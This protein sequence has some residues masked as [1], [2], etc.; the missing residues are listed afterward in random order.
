[1][2]SS[3]TS[4]AW[5]KSWLWCRIL[6]TFFGFYLLMLSYGFWICV[7]VRYWSVVFFYWNVFVWLGIRVLGWRWSHRMSWEVFPLLLSYEEILGNWKNSSHKCL[8]EFISEPNGCSSFFVIHFSFH[9]SDWI[10]S[11]D[12]YSGLMIPLPTQICSWLLL[13]S[14]SVPLLF[15]SG[16][17][18]W[19]FMYFFSLLILFIWWDIVFIL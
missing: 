18:V 11:V 17:S 9:S 6:F 13:V 4:L 8:V 14:T 2:I 12:L 16:I 10:T 7:H 15:Q 3:W 5:D 1:M 19:S